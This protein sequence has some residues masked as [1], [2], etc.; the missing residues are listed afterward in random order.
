M[1]TNLLHDTRAYLSGPM[2]FVGSRVVEKYLGWRAIL[3]PILRALSVTVLDPWNKPAVLG[4]ADEYGAEG[5]LPSKAQYEIDFWTNSETRARF[6][7]DFWETVHIDLR[8]T[9]I[10]DFVVT[11]V[12]TNIYS[13]GTVHE[14]ITA[15]NQLKPVLLVSPPI[16]YDFFSALDSL[17]AKQREA[18]KFYGL[19][20]NPHGLPSQ[21][22]GNIVGGHNMFDGFGW[23]SL[24]F[25]SESFYRELIG[26][27][28]EI[29]AE[30]L[31]DNAARTKW[32]EVREW[33]ATFRPLQD[34]K[35]GVLDHVS[36]P[37]Q[38]ERKLLENA[39][40]RRAEQDRKFFWYN[41]QYRPK[42]PFLYHLFSIASGHIPPKTTII[43]EIGEDGIVQY[44]K[45]ASIDDNWLLLA[46]DNMQP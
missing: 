15:R 1:K 18:L 36:F 3:A 40:A 31:E 23:E 42:R 10:S 5:L 27:T 28:L 9:D 37:D 34:L 21:W 33:V 45:V 24:E 4:H 46:A 38:H 17:T 2:D 16:Q 44:R 32:N 13:V 14:I 26:Q 19:K 7:Q 11:F 41:N 12:P 29:A 35:G 43:P 25:K 8:M 39:L 20:E 6:E 22:Y 30:H